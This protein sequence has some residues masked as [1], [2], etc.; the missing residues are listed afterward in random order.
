MIRARLKPI[1]EI[2]EKFLCCEEARRS[3]AL[4]AGTIECD[5]DPAIVMLDAVCGHC[6]RCWGHVQSRRIIALHDGPFLG[7]EI[8][9]ECFEFDEGPVA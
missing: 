1:E 3:M 7:T 2:P 4:Y 5:V 8:A 9:V 6:K